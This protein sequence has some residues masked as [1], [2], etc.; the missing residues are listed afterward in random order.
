MTAIDSL[1]LMLSGL[2]AKGA[3]FNVSAQDNLSVRAP[4]GV[5][6]SDLAA[7]L[8]EHRNE[9]IRCLAN[10][11]LVRKW[12]SRRITEFSF[13]LDL[14]PEFE[15]RVEDAI[16]DF[17]DGK[18]EFAELEAAWARFV[19]ESHAEREIVEERL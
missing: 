15:G 8:K 5:V 11:H 13:P 18:I 14:P 16:V 4:K 19:T 7:Y 9:V 12:L 17:I 1:H 3:M 2:K 6:S 10:E